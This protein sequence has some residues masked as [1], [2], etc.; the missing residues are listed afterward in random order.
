VSIYLMP[1]HNIPSRWLTSA[2][3]IRCLGRQVGQLCIPV[4]P[5]AIEISHKS[6]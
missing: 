6:G 4:K 1:S 2:D 5:N 3:D